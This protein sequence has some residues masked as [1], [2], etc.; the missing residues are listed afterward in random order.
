[1]SSDIW[2]QGQWLE[3][4][5]FF[6]SMLVMWHSMCY[7]WLWAV[8]MHYVGPDAG[9]PG[10]HTTSG[11]RYHIN[12]CTAYNTHGAETV[13][14]WSY[15]LQF[16]AFFPLSLPSN[17]GWW[18]LI[19]TITCHT[20]LPRNRVL[21]VVCFRVSRRLTES[22]QT[23]MPP[24]H[25]FS[26]WRRTLLTAF[27]WLAWQPTRKPTVTW[28]TQPVATSGVTGNL[29]GRCQRLRT[30]LLPAS[31]EWLKWTRIWTLSTRR[32]T[33]AVPQPMM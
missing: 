30:R 22:V 3:Y 28:L 25:S 18:T 15:G 9:R 21:C 1:M 11:T 2:W 19:S 14:N 12:H 13:W 24:S 16:F 4:L 8:R 20:V 7:S 32:K 29:I 10:W 17:H 33:C 5:T 6:C 23:C 31:V 27:S 26:L